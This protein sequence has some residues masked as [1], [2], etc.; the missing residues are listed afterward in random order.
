MCD[1][2]QCIDAYT[3]VVWEEM[4]SHGGNRLHEN[5]INLL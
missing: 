3:L 5:M 4:N 1:A 2:S